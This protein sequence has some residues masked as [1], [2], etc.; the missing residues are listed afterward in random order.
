MSHVRGALAGNRLILAGTILCLLCLYFPWGPLLHTISG[1]PPV[2]GWALMGGA[3]LVIALNRRVAFHFPPLLLAGVA[4]LVLPVFLMPAHAE[5]WLAVCRVLVMIG[6]TLLLARLAGATL[7]A[8]RAAYVGWMLVLLTT[9]C[10]LAVLLQVF[11]PP[12]YAH[13]LMIPVSTRPFGFF[14][15]TSV[16]A[17]FLA[18]GVALLLWFRLS[19]GG[20]REL[21]LLFVL[22][23]ALTLCQSMTGF[24]GA[25]LAGVLMLVCASSRL[26]LRLVSA[27][28]VMAAGVLAGWLTLHYHGHGLVSADLPR[29]VRLQILEATIAL[30]RAHPLTGTG[31]GMFES[32]F[33]SGLALA[34]LTG[35]WHG[36]R[37]ITHPGN[38]ILYWVAEGGIVA[39]VGGLCLVLFALCTFIRLWRQSA[40]NG[41]LGQPGTDA[42]AWGLCML[43][44]LLH[45]QTGSP[46]YTSPLHF[47]LLV[48]LAG[49]ALG[50][51]GATPVRLMNGAGAV[52]TRVLV[53]VTGI[54]ALAWVLSGV[55]ISV[56]VDQARQTMAKDV[57][58]LSAATRYNP[59]FAPDDAGFAMTMHDLQA[60]NTSHDLSLLSSSNAFFTDYLT[61]HPD[62]NVYSTYI[63]SLHFQGKTNEAE[64]VY[65]AGQK[66]VPW[67]RRFAPDDETP[68]DGDAAAAAAAEAATH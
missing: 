2:A 43:P 39:A 11:L 37:L 25:G 7:S 58:A 33:P 22:M 21:V 20:R 49:L 18:T 53:F 45:T 40:Q 10:A 6:G 27:I 68:A 54:A 19:H 14:Y 50:R 30:I 12:Q 38:E 17:S 24:L 35:V 9:A 65:E 26:R 44:V 4:L 34:G 23:F 28:V 16:M 64:Q 8:A 15:Q 36:A 66:R 31:Y 59:W 3:F 1:L 13:I 52:V 32:E 41:G 56:G 51:A 55:W 46:W 57:S 5:R 63:T 61:R 42:L 29:Q 67:D 47:L 62:P 48:L 60:F